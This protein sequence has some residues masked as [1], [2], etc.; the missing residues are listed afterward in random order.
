MLKNRNIFIRLMTVLRAIARRILLSKQFEDHLW[1][2][3]E[4]M[5][6]IKTR[7]PLCRQGQIPTH[8]YF[9][10]RGMITLSYK[11]PSG[12]R[13][14][15]RMYRE[16]RICGLISFILQLPSLYTIEV[17]KGAMLLS[18]D[19]Q[20]LTRLYQIDERL[21][22]FVLVTSMHYEHYKE[23]F[24][25]NLLF[26][27]TSNQKVE[28]FYEIFK[29]LLNTRRVVLDEDIAL[30]LHISPSA[31]IKARRVYRNKLKLKEEQAIKSLK[32]NKMDNFSDYS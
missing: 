31:L 4:E 18:I 15:T 6:D 21:K 1:E 27:K 32:T 2:D 9:V 28:E 26:D 20:A 19:H 14:V 30:Y 13:H 17:S 23:Q 11:D 10:V 7:R 8:A 16:N 12:K 5:T 24:R 29:G 3:M 25:E 22:E